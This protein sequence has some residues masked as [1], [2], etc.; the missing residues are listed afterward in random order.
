[1]AA[2]RNKATLDAMWATLESLTPNSSAEEIQKLQQYY[3]PDAVVYLNGMTAP[4]AKGHEEIKEEV[5]K[6]VQYWVSFIFRSQ[7]NEE[8][9][10]AN[11]V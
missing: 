6:L 2:Q 1:M 5:G 3:E 4:P 10:K 9:R 11:S 7:P 8:F